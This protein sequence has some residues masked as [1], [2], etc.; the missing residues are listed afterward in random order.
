MRAAVRPFLFQ[1]AP[2]VK[3]ATPSTLGV[4]MTA[5]FQS[6]PPV[7]GATLASRYR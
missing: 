4:P 5:E 3:G 1:S 6:A 7:K 2:P